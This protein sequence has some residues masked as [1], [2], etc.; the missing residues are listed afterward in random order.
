MSEFME[1]HSVAR[2]V[3][4]PPGY[5]GY[6]EGG[7]LT[8]AVRRRPYAVVLLDEVEKAH[9]DVFNILLQVLD[10]G[11]LTDGQGRTVDF[12]N[13]VIVMTSNLGSDLILDVAGEEN[14]EEIKTRV[15]EVVGQ[16][17]RPEFINRLD[18]MV[19]F[20]PLK[21]D[22]VRQIAK[23]QLNYLHKRLAEKDLS[24]NV[25]EDVVDV[26]AAKGFDPVYGARPLKRVIKNKIEKELAK[27]ILGG[28]FSPGD[29]INVEM[30][31]NIMTFSKT[32]AA[33]LI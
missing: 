12:R 4:A 15:L 27:R 10:D 14:Y 2:L 8:E 5:V 23:I 17:F 13:T 29:T 33:D 7:Y 32:I 26:I 25:S 18:E 3:G 24:L 11:R 19:V 31:D 6:E 1:K 21:Q 22:Q 30:E 9:P 20:H 28:E 16:H